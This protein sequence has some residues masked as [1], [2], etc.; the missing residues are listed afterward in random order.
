[1][2]FW[3]CFAYMPENG[4]VI[5]VHREGKVLEIFVLGGIE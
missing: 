4:M 2:T 5:T 1:M 3:N